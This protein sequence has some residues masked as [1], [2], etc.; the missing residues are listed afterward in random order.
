M[1]YSCTTA[2][3]TLLWAA[4]MPGVMRAQGQQGSGSPYSAYGLGGLVGSTQA[5]QAFMGGAS[6]AVFDPF[7]VIHANPAS[8]PM[9]GRPV[10][11][12]A[13]VF[14]N[15]QFISGDQSQAG[16]RMDLLG[17]TFGVPFGNGRWGLALGMNPVSKVGYTVSSR[18]TIPG[19]TQEVEFQYSGLGGLDRAFM[20]LGHNVLLKRD[21]IGN[22]HR[23]SVGANF[24]YLFGTIDEVRKAYYPRTTGFLNSQVV[25]SLVLRDPVYDL[26]VQFQGDLIKRRDRTDE[27]LR[28]IVG[29]SVEL[30]SNLNARRDGLVSTFILGGAA[31][32]F[33]VDTISFEQG[34]QGA[35]GLPPL[36]ILGVTVYNGR[37]AVTLEHR[38][39]DWRQLRVDLP[40]S[41]L[42]YDLGN[43]TS[44][45]VGGS[46]RPAGDG[47]GNFW[48]STIYRAGLRFTDDY[49]VVGGNQLQEIG[50]S[51]GM[52]LPLMGSTTRSRL[53]IGAEL[54]SKGS[55]EEGLIEQ[56][57]AN[58][59]IGI[60][61]TP[62]LREQWFKKRR[63]E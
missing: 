45:V 46:Y 40:G 56:R 59:F 4:L 53:N 23:L 18:E 44:Y 21:S 51:F 11:E 49:L 27:G 39:R 20:R 22:G 34:A 37:W 54:G 63:I 61:I 55:R 14:R 16:R 31:V 57:F 25:S 35:L 2:L 10:F 36:Y 33:P 5:S 7:S 15:Q 47:R 6:V 30:P 9:L 60:T 52:S 19:T 58:V 3:W 29:A 32:E 43:N 62:D 8:Y 26:G 38:R 41:D 24:N 12:T 1:R 13:V 17:L 42:Q 48:E 50:M 28:F